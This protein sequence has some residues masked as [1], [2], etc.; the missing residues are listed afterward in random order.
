MTDT[1]AYQIGAV[2]F[3]AALFMTGTLTRGLFPT[4]IFKNLKLA[5]FLVAALM[6][7]FVLYLRLPDISS[8]LDLTALSTPEAPAQEAPAPAV[9]IKQRGALRPATKAQDVQ[10]IHQAEP[11]LDATSQPQGSPNPVVDPR[12]PTLSPPQSNASSPPSSVREDS[13]LAGSW[14]A[15]PAQE[16]GNRVTRAMKSVGHFLHIGHEKYQP[17]PVAPQPAT[18][19]D[20]EKAQSAQ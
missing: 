7:G 5:M 19:A 20:Q 9:V 13:A 12:P 2:F 1:L 4:G 3:L 6:V 17:G 8:V 16:S 10:V 15:V 14:R 11:A 18:L